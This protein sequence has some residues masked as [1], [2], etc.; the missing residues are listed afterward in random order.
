MHMTKVVSLS[1]RAYD[2]MK[3]IKHSD[4]SFSDVVI[5][6]IN[7]SKKRSLSDFVGRWP[8]P[9][10]ELDRIQKILDEDRKKFN[11]REVKFD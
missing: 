3:A 5:R 4:E 8:G 9:P 7:R 6:L 2:E 11:L 1:N 10:E